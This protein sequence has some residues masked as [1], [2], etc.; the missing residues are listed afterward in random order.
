[1]KRQGKQ[2]AQALGVHDALGA[3]DGR[4]DGVSEGHHQ[5][6]VAP[7]LP[8]LLAPL[9]PLVGGVHRERGRQLQA[10]ERVVL[11]VVEGLQLLGA[12]GIIL[13]AGGGRN[14]TNEEKKDRA[15]ATTYIRLMGEEV[16]GD[17]EVL[18][19]LVLR[20]M[21]TIVEQAPNRN[22]LRNGTR[23]PKRSK[24]YHTCLPD[25]PLGNPAC[26]LHT[27]ILILSPTTP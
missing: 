10:Q 12:E 1:M 16:R 25:R 18:F 8:P 3:D 7:R 6:G 20:K 23:M 5:V 21:R 26:L 11:Q 19:V 14:K 27:P 13:A 2:L 9:V 24:G 17:F 15:I 4:A 22:Q